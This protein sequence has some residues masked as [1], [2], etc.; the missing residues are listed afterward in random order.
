MSQPRD[1]LDAPGPLPDERPDTI[2]GELAR[3]L[4]D[5]DIDV[6]IQHP[7][8]DDVTIRARVAWAD[9]AQLLFATEYA[10]DLEIYPSGRID[11]TL[12]A[13]SGPVCLYTQI[14]G[15]LGLPIVVGC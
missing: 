2:G 10:V 15:G 7:E 6:P 8:W 5:L 11:A 13:R 14:T 12:V 3:R 1:I 4:A 9:M